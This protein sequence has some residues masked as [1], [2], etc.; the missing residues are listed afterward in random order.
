VIDPAEM[1]RAISSTL[2]AGADAEAPVPARG[3]VDTW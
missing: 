3:F 1:R 2:V